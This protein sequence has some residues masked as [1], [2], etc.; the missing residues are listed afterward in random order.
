MRRITAAV[1]FV[2]IACTPASAGRVSFEQSVT[3]IDP[4]A[5]DGLVFSVHIMLDQLDMREFEAFNIL[6]GSHD[7]RIVDFE[8]DGVPPCVDCPVPFALGKYP[9]DLRIGFF[10]AVGPLDAPFS[11]GTLTVDASGLALGIYEILV[12]GE[13]DFQS[14]AVSGPHAEALFG[15]GRIQ[16]V[17]EPAT[18]TLL[19]IAALGLLRRTRGKCPE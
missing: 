6:V 15:V 2:A 10:S 19:G 16:I 9:S 17:P 3:V 5:G 18:L 7:L 4:S 14:R 11:L 13:F 12:D 1:F 8:F